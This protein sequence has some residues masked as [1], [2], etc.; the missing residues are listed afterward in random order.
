MPL[1]RAAQIYG[2]DTLELLYQV[3]D[4]CC[5]EA[6]PDGRVP[7]AERENLRKKLAVTI[8]GAYAAG[9]H[10]PAELKRIA[11]AAISSGSG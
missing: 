1:S 5:A 11:L 3:F 4:E 8:I 2:Q 7:P 10:Q 9:E 6:I